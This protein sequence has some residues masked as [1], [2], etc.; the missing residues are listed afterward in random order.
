MLY[1][2]SMKALLRLHYLDAHELRLHERLPVVIIKAAEGR[3][4]QY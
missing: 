3:E 1:E 2:G 4:G